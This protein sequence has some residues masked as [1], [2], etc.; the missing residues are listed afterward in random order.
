MRQARC[1]TVSRAKYRLKG[2][3]FAL[4]AIFALETVWQLLHITNF[5]SICKDTTV[6]SI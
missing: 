4:E 1:R 6:G 3:E 5:C 2:T